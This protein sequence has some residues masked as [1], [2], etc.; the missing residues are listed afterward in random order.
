[1]NASS[2]A[3]WAA[4][5]SS[6]SLSFPAF[7]KAVSPR[8]LSSSLLILSCSRSAT[9][10]ARLMSTCTRS[11]SFPTI[12]RFSFTFCS[13]MRISSAISSSS[14]TARLARRFCSRLS[15]STMVASAFW[16][17]STRGII[18]W[19]LRSWACRSSK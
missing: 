8:R 6:N 11:A 5:Y 18:F 12:S 9:F 19:H 4:V 7:S 16:T 17:A 2:S 15:R 13:E 10:W 14:S 3:R 1:M